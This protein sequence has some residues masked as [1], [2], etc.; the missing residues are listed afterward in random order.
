VQLLTGAAE[1]AVAGDGGEVLEL[2]DAHGGLR[3]VI[4]SGV[5]VIGNAFHQTACASTAY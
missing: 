1:R 2:F 4:G 3:S 5:P